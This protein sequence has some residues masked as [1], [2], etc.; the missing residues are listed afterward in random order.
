[1]DGDSGNREDVRRIDVDPSD[2]HVVI[3]GG[4]W[5]S[6]PPPSGGAPLPWLRRHRAKL[7]LGLAAVELLVFG[8]GP[9]GFLRNW[10]GLLA[11]AIAAVVLHVVAR[12]VLPYTLQQITWTIALAQ[13]LVALAPVFLIGSAIVI[14]ILL[15]FVALVGLA[16]LFAD[17]R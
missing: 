11:I 8:F 13:S 17:R 16:L 9:G 6:A 7:A 10:L 5:Y 2:V 12:R 3:S 14:A 15:V 1:M 4:S